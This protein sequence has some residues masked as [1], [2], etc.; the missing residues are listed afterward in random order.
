MNKDQITG[1]V[2]EIA[3][4]VQRKIGEV[5]GSNEQ[6]IHGAV[7]EVQGKTQQIVGDVKQLLTDAQPHEKK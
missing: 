4:T 3:G 7:K 2:K 6:R 5:I 1:T